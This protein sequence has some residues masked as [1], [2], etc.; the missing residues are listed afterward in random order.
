MPQSGFFPSIGHLCFSGAC[1]LQHCVQLIKY[2]KYTMI[3]SDYFSEFFPCEAH[4]LKYDYTL[5]LKEGFEILTSKHLQTMCANSQ[6]PWA[7]EILGTIEG[8]NCFQPGCQA[9]A[10][11][12]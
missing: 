2:T 8:H 3:S 4:A 6:Y 5:D 10:Y 7:E 1:F 9:V 12:D 11:P